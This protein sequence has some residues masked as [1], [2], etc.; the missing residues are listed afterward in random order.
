MHYLSHFDAFFPLKINKLWKFC[1]LL[2]RLE[3]CSIGFSMSWTLYMHYSSH[4]DAFLQLK[5]NK[6]WNFGCFLNSFLTKHE[7][8]SIWTGKNASKRLANLPIWFLGIPI[9]MHYVRTLCDECCFELLWFFCI[10]YWNV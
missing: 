2:L 4:F 6:I 1:H 10:F 9:I 5:I 8:L 7:N 3:T